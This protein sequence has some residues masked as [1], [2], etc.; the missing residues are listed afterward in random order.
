MHEHLFALEQDLLNPKIRMNQ[1]MLER[2]LSPDFF[3]FGSSGTVWTRKDILQRL[4]NET[5]YQVNASDFQAHPLAD[6]T[7]L[8]TYKTQRTEPDGAI[9]RAIRS[10]IWVRNGASWQMR[11]HQGTKM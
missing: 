7:V 3:E 5:P 11:F 1:K 6:N 2:L 4:P 8:V 9:F 10:S